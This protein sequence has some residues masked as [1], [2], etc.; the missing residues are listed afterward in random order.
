MSGVEVQLLVDVKGP[1][2]SG[3][4]THSSVRKPI[5]Y[6]KHIFLVAILFQPSDM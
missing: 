1:N 6:G 2:L 4:E 5:P 3:G